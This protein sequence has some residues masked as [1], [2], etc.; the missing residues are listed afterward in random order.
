MRNA[1]SSMDAKFHADLERP[2]MRLKIL[3]GAFALLAMVS[4]GS[5]ANLLQNGDFGSA[6]TARYDPFQISNAT[7][8]NH[9]VAWGYS[10]TTG[11]GSD[12]NFAKHDTGGGGGDF[13]LVQ[14]IDAAAS[15][16][17]AG[18]TLQLEY[19]YIYDYSSSVNTN[20]PRGIYLI[21][22]KSDRS[23]RMYLGEGV[24][25]VSGGADTSVALPD[26]L[27]A[28]LSNNALAKST[29][30]S[31]DQTLSATLGESFDYIGV[32]FQASCYDPTSPTVYCNYDR[33]L[34]NVSLT[35]TGQA[36]GVPEPTTLALLG[37][38]LAGLAAARRRKP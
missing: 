9:W 3:A 20:L 22:V 30:W 35:I 29:T 26:L 27:L 12:G 14:F 37:L 11:V 1:S 21:G 34:D 32:V 23:Y 31:R 19:D 2:T 15:G 33:G 28:S 36:P 24:D 5:S 4:G 6:I 7:Y 13:R 8:L 16:V 25:G 18:T 17:I 10:T 38:G